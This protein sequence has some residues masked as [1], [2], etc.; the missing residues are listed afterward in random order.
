M[1]DS[2]ETLGVDLKTR[3]KRLGVEEKSEKEEVQGE[4]LACQEEQSRP[5]ELHEGG[6]QE[7]ATSLYGASKN[8]ESTCGGDGPYRKFKIEEADGSSSGHKEHD[9]FVIVL[10][11]IWS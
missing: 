1:A 7:V 10:G 8:V 2:V 6:R 5:K 3:V 4:I 9:L 11:S